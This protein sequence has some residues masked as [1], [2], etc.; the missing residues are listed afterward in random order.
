M[1]VVL[2][3][4]FNRNTAAFDCYFC[5]IMQIVAF[6]W[7]SLKG[8]YL[9]NKIFSR[10]FSTVGDRSRNL[11][12]SISLSFKIY[13]FYSLLIFIATIS[14]LNGAI[15]LN[16]LVDVSEKT[17]KIISNFWCRNHIHVFY[18][19]RN[20]AWVLALKVS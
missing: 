7:V 14:S 17:I 10:L 11:V 6:I 18:F 2:H 15:N 8:P 20:L 1:L 4:G 19:I 12:F 16:L 5:V 9:L 3:I 13:L